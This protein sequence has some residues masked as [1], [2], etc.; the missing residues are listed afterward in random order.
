MGGVVIWAFLPE[1]GPAHSFE[2]TLQ[3]SVLEKMAD[4]PP[5]PYSVEINTLFIFT[6]L[7]DLP[8]GG[9]VSQLTGETGENLNTLDYNYKGIWPPCCFINVLFFASH[10]HMTMSL[11]HWEEGQGFFSVFFPD[12][13]HIWGRT[14]LFDIPF[15]SYHLLD[16]WAWHNIPNST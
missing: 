16:L 15:L 10:A 4:G 9:V 6:Q 11:T 13:K 7:A 8:Q 5:H 12:G 14:S 3:H 2:L 1:A